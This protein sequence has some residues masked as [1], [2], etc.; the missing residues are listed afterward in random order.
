MV[1]DLQTTRS[2]KAEDKD[3]ERQRRAR[4]RREAD[5]GDGRPRV[6]KK[7]DGVCDPL[8]E[9]FKDGAR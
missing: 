7:T 8:L 4:Y 2:T 6:D 1:S 3:R 5:Q 9:A